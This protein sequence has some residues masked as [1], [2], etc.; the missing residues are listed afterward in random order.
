MT[1]A[2]IFWPIP[3]PVRR[4]ERSAVKKPPGNRYILFIAITNL[5]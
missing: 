4:M 1:G 2:W 3:I 5:L